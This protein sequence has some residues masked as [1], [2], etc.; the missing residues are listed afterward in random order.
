VVV[1]PIPKPC[2]RCGQLTEE[3]SRCAHCEAAWQ[4]ARERRRPSFRERRGTGGWSWAAVRAQ[5][6]ARDGGRCVN[7]GACEHLE[8]HHVVPLRAGGTDEP[9]NLVTLCR[10]CHGRARS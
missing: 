5:V 4:A 2:L 9:G 10:A 8:V 6:R 3:G 1:S 7:C